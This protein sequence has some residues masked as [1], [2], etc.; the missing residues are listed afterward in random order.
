MCV[1]CACVV[2]QGGGC[3]LSTVRAVCFAP[4]CTRPQHTRLVPTSPHTIHTPRPQAHM[5][6]LQGA[7]RP[8]HQP[9]QYLVYATSTVHSYTNSYIANNLL[10]GWCRLVAPHSGAP[11]IGSNSRK[12]VAQHGCQPTHTFELTLPLTHGSHMRHVAPECAPVLS[13][14]SAPVLGRHCC[15]RVA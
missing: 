1:C 2:G 5:R 13:D 15:T 9:I 12:R 14:S 6:Y 7:Y 3:Q 10:G 11:V 4:A 8:L